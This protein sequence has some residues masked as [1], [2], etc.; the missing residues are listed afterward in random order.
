MILFVFEGNEREPRL[1]RTLERLYFPKENGNIIC[2]FG[3]NIFDLYNELLEYGDG[4]DIV[5]LMRERLASRGD[6]ILGGIRSADISEIFL[7]FDYDFQHSQLSL[8]EINNRV[9]KMLS[10]FDE[11]TGNGKLYINY[12]MIVSISY[13]KELP[14]NDYA[15]YMVSR[16]DC[17]DFKNLAREFSAYNSYDHILFKDGEIPTKAKYLKLKDNWQYLRQMNVSKANLLTTGCYTI[18]DGKSAINQLSVFNNQVE[19]YVTPKDCVSILNTF[20][21]FIY[22]YMKK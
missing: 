8:E 13:T 14:D 12:P 5:S 17:R 4:G 19:K 10:L 1:F 3:N 7:F 6:S 21:I 11:E 18:P 15:G 2:S 20:P 16:E 22:E 9:Q